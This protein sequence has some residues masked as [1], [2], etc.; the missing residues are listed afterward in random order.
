[1]IDK[2]QVCTIL[3]EM[4]KDEDKGIMEYENLK[5]QLTTKRDKAI[6]S[7]ILGDE[8]RHARKVR[9]IYNRISCGIQV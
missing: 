1:M 8:K 5:S 2:T 6:V 3:G 9:M 4:I 7:K